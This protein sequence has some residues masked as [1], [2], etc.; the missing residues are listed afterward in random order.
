MAI[1]N[2]RT[3]FIY[4][5]GISLLGL[6]I[7]VLLSS[8]FTSPL[9]SEIPKRIASFRGP[10]TLLS[11]K[12]FL[13]NDDDDGSLGTNA[14]QKLDTQHDFGQHIS[15]VPGILS[16]YNATIL[17]QLGMI[18]NE[19]DRQKKRLG[20]QK[21]AFNVLIS[22]RIGSHR[23]I[24]DTRFP[25]CKNKT[26]SSLNSLPKSSIIICFYNEAPSVLKRTIFS[27]LNRSQKELIKE[28]ILIDDHRSLSLDSDQS[29]TEFQTPI[30]IRRTPERAG[31]IRARIYGAKFAQGDVL[32][33][34]DSHCEVNHDWLRPLVQRIHENR[35]VVTI[36]IIDIISHNTF[37]YSASPLV[38]GGFNWGLHFKW[39]AI[40][41]SLLRKKSDYVKP[42]LS[43]TM[44]GGLFAMDRKYFH[45]LGEY[46][47]GMDIWGGENLEISFRVW[48]CGG[49]L[50]IIPCSRVGHV[51]RQRRPYGSPDGEDTLMKNSLRVA[52]VWM[53][54]FKE[55]FYKLRRDASKINF[56]DVSGRVELRKKLQCKSFAWYL[57]NIYPELKSPGEMDQMKKRKKSRPG[58]F[59]NKYMSYKKSKRKVLAVFQLQLANTNLCI[60]SEG[61][62]TKKKSFLLLKECKT[63]KRQTW[64]ET[65]LKELRLSNILCLD[66]VGD[67]PFLV[68]CHGLGESQEWN[69]SGK[70]DSPLYNMA[71][72]L[73]LG[74]LRPQADEPV[75]MA[76]CSDRRSRKWNIIS[77]ST[78]S[79]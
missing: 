77:N 10:E 39:D 29:F 12:N 51:F 69:H 21:Y 41:S 47:S 46:D 44:A 17:K 64:Y 37:E 5:I 2:L 4:V 9:E 6:I 71:A 19:K 72:G 50:E 60:E 24:P 54:E 52:N 55:N 78:N 73:C 43:P 40:P 45:E 63:T 56:G 8:N 49:S 28:I 38:R 79:L 76:I 26:Y 61:E 74:S 42:I 32:V 65:D 11:L 75:I 35:K 3:L 57:E 20:F 70:K 66:A 27:I 34:L 59:K 67:Q 33:F 30:K 68:K 14:L 16:H 53:D 13:Q 1:S 48:M 15:H 25:L 18:R 36:P 62:V 23:D 22:D 31:L 7:F 58:K